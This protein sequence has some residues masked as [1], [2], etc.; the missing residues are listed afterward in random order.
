MLKQDADRYTWVAA[1]IGANNASGYQLA[2][3][4]PVMAIGGFNGSDPSPTLAQFQ[5]YVADGKIHWFIGGGGMGSSPARARRAK[6]PR[7]WS[8][9]SPRPRST[10]SRSTTSRRQRPDCH[11]PDSPPPG[12]P[13]AARR[14]RPRPASAPAPERVSPARCDSCRGRSPITPCEWMWVVGGTPNCPGTALAGDRLSHP[15][16]VFRS[17]QLLRLC[18]GGVS[19]ARPW[20][21][22]FR[23][24]PTVLDSRLHLR[25][26]QIVSLCL[27]EHNGRFQNDGSVRFFSDDVAVVL[28][29]EPAQAHA[30]SAVHLDNQIAHGV[31]SF[32]GLFDRDQRFGG[33]ALARCRQLPP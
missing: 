1:T 25:V 22:L 7:G 24:L 17:P 9:T 28:V 30:V 15:C 6:S 5:Q 20:P 26:R 8:R 4:R 33:S 32:S 27:S 23:V 19:A 11:R 31:T 29:S 16:H 18:G 21:A 13:A 2:I 3:E 12:H 14:H 10:G